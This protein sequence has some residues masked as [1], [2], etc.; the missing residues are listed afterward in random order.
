MWLGNAYIF[1][2]PEFFDIVFGVFLAN[3]LTYAVVRSWMSIREAGD[4]TW[5]T[6]FSFA[7]PLLATAAY[8]FIAL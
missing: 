7:G 6:M 2:M 8:A 3:L 5:G 4:T 1:G